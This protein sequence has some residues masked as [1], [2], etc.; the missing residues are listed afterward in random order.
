MFPSFLITFREVLEASLIV[1]TV[2]GILIRLGDRKSIRSVWYST[3]AAALASVILVVGSS[4]MGAT[5]R[6][7]YEEFAEVIEGLLM[8][9]TAGFITWAVFFL[10]R[11]F[12]QHKAK[13]LARVQEM[14]ATDERRGLFA[15][16]FIAVFREG[17]EI[18]FFL[19]GLLFSA[20]AM[21][22]LN[23][24]FVGILAAIMLALIFF[25]G[26]QRLPI[27]YAVRG[28]NALLILYA[29]SLFVR[30]IEE[31]SEP[32]FSSLIIMGTQSVLFVTYVAVM[33]YLIFFRSR[34]EQVR[35]VIV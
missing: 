1:A 17:L 14:L 13:L 32:Y 11:F 34:V 30:G 10:H 20:S 21:V 2:I 7:R 5:I 22:I 19:A 18:V 25:V 3:I 31:L 33:V 23:G 28:A 9:T 15:L 12:V 27:L 4:L 35:K 6:E 24:F 26:A 29:A 8:I 16:V